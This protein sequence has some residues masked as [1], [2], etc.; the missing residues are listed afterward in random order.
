MNPSHRLIKL[1]SAARKRIVKLRSLVSPFSIP[2]RAEDERVVAWAVI[3]ALNL[4]AS[5]LRAYYL[6]G[7]VGTRAVTGMAVFSTLKA[8]PNTDSALKYA[9]AFKTRTFNKTKISR[10]DEPA[11]HDTRLFLSLLGSIGVSNLA[12]IHAAFSC[13][14]TFFDHLPTVRNFYAHRCDET[15]RKATRVGVKL[16]VTVVPTLRP[17]EIM[18]AQMPKRPGNVITD[19]LDEMANVVDLLC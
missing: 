12:Q 5:F 13:G 3:E 7:V 14:S 15:F 11:W 2:I 9:C 19:W 1:K 8:F 6:S 18:C 10:R 17:T 16:G 4:W